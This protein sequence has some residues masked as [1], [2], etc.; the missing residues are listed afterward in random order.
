VTKE[1]ILQSGLIEQYVLGLASTEEARQV[2]QCAAL[3][4]EVNQQIEE[5]NQYLKSYATQNGL[6]E[7]EDIPA[8]IQEEIDAWDHETEDK[9][10][11]NQRRDTNQL[12][13]VIAGAIAMILGAICL[14]LFQNNHDQQ[15]ELHEQQVKIEH[16][17][18][19]VEA[20]KQSTTTIHSS[21][22]TSVSI[23]IRNTKACLD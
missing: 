17:E 10:T 23:P 16:L 4:P 14:I 1:Q 5:L 7:G 19:Q 13:S 11:R 21:Q 2:E 3:Y 9:Q 12:F 8:R 22:A 6:P 15:K 20:L 18:K